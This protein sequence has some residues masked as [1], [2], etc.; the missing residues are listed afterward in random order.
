MG[1][2]A[3]QVVVV[4][5]VSRG[6]GRALTEKFAAGGHTVL[7]CGRSREA[8]DELR[9][10]LGPPHDFDA[11]DVA[12]T[13]QVAAWAA[14]LLA[15]YGPPDLLVN[16]AALL[17]RPAPLW[18]VPAAEFDQLI[19]V[20]V[21]GVANVLRHFLPA[22]VAKNH[23]VVVN[24]SS[25]LGRSAAGEVAPYCA[26][27]FAVEGLTQALSQELPRGMAAVA[28]NPG[29]IDTDML[30]LWGASGGNPSPA[31]W[32]ERAVPF[33][34]QLGRKDNGRPLSVPG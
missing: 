4:T 13:A 10:R 26:S 20:N 5:G 17:N 21:K 14:R 29:V 24:F 15:A 27:K 34:L 12:D 7:G 3:S 9:R 23:G 22:M 33:L 11:V 28:L 32:A 19:D 8:G 1:Q 30:R 6:L 16:N 25:G 31:E 18:Q 2:G